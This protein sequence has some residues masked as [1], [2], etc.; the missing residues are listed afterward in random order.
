MESLVVTVLVHQCHHVGP[1]GPATADVQSR[2][3]LGQRGGGGCWSR[4][5]DRVAGPQGRAG[6]GWA[7]GFVEGR[8]LSGRQARPPCLHVC[9][10]SPTAATTTYS[11]SPPGTGTSP[12]SCPTMRSAVRCECE[13][14]RAASR[15]PTPGPTA[16]DRRIRCLPLEFPAEHGVWHRGPHSLSD[17]PGALPRHEQRPRFLSEWPPSKVQD[18]RDK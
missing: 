6:L 4:G 3:R 8:G 5:I 2:S 18:G 16:A 1:T 7:A 15:R 12:R 10:F 17:A 14:D 13:S 9:L 11:P